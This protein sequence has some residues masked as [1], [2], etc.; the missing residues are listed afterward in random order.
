MRCC[1]DAPLCGELRPVGRLDLDTSGLL[2]WTTDGAEIQRLT[3][4]K[5]AV[6]RTYQAALAR[7]FAPLPDEAGPRRRARTAGDGPGA[8]AARRRSHPEPADPARDVRAGGDHHRRRRLPRGP[9]HLRRARQPRARALPRPLRRRRAPAR[10]L[11][12]RIPAAAER[13]PG[14]DRSARRARRAGDPLEHRQRGAHLPGRRRAAS[15]RPAA[16]V[17]ARRQG[18]AARRPRLLAARPPRGLAELGRLRARAAVAGD[19]VLL[20]R[21][22]ARASSR[23]LPTRGPRC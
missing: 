13:G 9:P 6:P 18:G 22:A 17:L 2:L 15:S 19:A 4:P 23:R 1:A 3:H 7:P 12:R 8:L 21:R 10:S 11:A 20:H 16:R 5:R 14:D